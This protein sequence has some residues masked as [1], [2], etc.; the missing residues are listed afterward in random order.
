MGEMN[1]RM[2]QGVA[3]GL[4]AL[5]SAYP[6]SLNCDRGVRQ[7]ASALTSQRGRVCSQVRGQRLKCTVCKMVLDVLPGMAV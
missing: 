2:L 1:I 4:S 5:T 7:S 3:F 6:L